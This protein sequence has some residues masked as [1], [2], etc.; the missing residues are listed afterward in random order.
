MLSS[1]LCYRLV[2]NKPNG[3]AKPLVERTCNL[4]HIKLIKCF[5]P[6]SLCALAYNKGQRHTGKAISGL[7]LMPGTQSLHL[8]PLLSLFA[9]WSY[10]ALAEILLEHEKMRCDCSTR[11]NHILHINTHTV[12]IFIWQAVVVAVVAPCIFPHHLYRSASLSL[13]LAARQQFITFQS[14][15][16]SIMPHTYFSSSRAKR[17]QWTVAWVELC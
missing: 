3:L 11:K 7:Q 2:F 4:L 5:T 9:C 6:H 8:S 12:Y 14:L 1:C 13:S 10:F 17:S 15:G 16:S